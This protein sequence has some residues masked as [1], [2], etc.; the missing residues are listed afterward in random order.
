MGLAETAS[1]D[2]VNVMIIED[3]HRDTDAQ[4]FLKEKT[5]IDEARKLAKEYC[6]YAYDYSEELNERMKKDG[7]IFHVTYS[8][9][10]D[11][12]RV[13]KRKVNSI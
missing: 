6:R 13:L 3:R 10:G 12:I 5:A 4:V 1:L 7:W 9:E 2:T 8:Y 11:N